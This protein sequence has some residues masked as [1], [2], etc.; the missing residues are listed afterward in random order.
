[1]YPCARLQKA[2]GSGRDLGLTVALNIEGE[3]YKATSRPY[4]GATVLINDPID[5]PDIGAQVASV[6]PGHVLAISVTG[7]LITS[8]ENMRSIPIEKRKCFFDD[9]VNA[10]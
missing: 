7:S 5:F 10:T 6:A 4:I 1:M 8:M 9:E 3:M 2:P